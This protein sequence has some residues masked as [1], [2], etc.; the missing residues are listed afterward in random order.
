MP[1][2]GLKLI[3]RLTLKVFSKQVALGFGVHYVSK[4]MGFNTPVWAT[5]LL[6]VAS[7]PLYCCYRVVEEAVRHRREANALGARLA[8]RVP[9]KWPGNFDFLRTMIHNRAHGYPTDGF[10]ELLAQLGPVMNTR[11]LWMDT[12]LTVWPEHIKII[13]A[14]DFNNYVKGERFQSNVGSVL[15]V[16]VFNADGEMWKFHRNITRPFFSR[17]KISH[18]DIFDSHASDVIRIM[19][20]RMR[21]GYSIDFQDLIGRF[22]MD[23]AT[24]FLFGTCVDSL[25]ANIPYGHNVAFPPPE[26]NSVQGQTA[27]KFIEAFNE[28]MQVIAHREYVGPIWPLGEMWCDRTAEPMRVVSAFL[29]PIINAAVERKREAETLEKK[30][31]IEAETL[32]DEL[33]NSTSDPKVLKDET[34][35]ILLAG[36]DTTMHTTTMV[37]YFLSMYPDICTRL[38][39]EVLTHVGPT[40]RPTYDDIKEMKFLR[41]VIN[42]S[43]RLY[44]SVP[45]NTRESIN[46]TTW[47]S[48]DPA[49]KPIYIPAGTKVPYSVLLMMRLKELWGPDADEFSPDRFLDERLKK[50]LISNPFQFLPFNGGPRICLGQQFA[51]NEMSFVII[52]LLQSFSSFALDQAACSQEGQTPAE[53]ASAPGRKG[54]DKFVPKSHLTMYTE[55]GMWIKAMNV[56]AEN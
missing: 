32:L 41:A 48:P 14:S 6:S 36:R 12:I 53:W 38:R 10:T 22:T 11:V 16:G 52:R 37:I 27:N 19:K 42:E 50:Y 43:M 51:Y 25:K 13:L 17:D 49:Q 54:V 21:G 2:P 33:L 3:A 34:L 9:G 24:E 40:R 31:D 26:S 35:N 18:F 23:S 28:S 29:D 45:F 1:T 4:R 55:G 5:V 39:E 20:D 44:P 8:P 30:G 46:A 7:L 47:P 15:G 56:E